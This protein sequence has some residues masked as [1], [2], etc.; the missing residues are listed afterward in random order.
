MESFLTLE[1]A[2]EETM[3]RTAALGTEEVELMD[4]YGRFL[5]KK[6][7]ARLPF[8]AF[9]RS[10]L[11]GYAVRAADLKDAP[12]TLR[13]LEEVGAGQVPTQVVGTGQATRIMTGAPIPVG[14]D[15][16]VRL[17]VTERVDGSHEAQTVPHVRILLTVAAG[18]AI[19]RQ[20]EDTPAGALLL[21]A[22]CQIGGAELA[23]LGANGVDR[24][25]VYRRPRV[26]VIVSGAEVRPAGQ[27]LEAGQVY[28]SNG[29][30]LAGLIREQGGHPILYGQVGDDLEA[31]ARL[32][33]KAAASCDLLLTTGGVSVGDYDL[34]RDAYV[35]AGGE[36]LFWKVSMRP[37]TPV[38]YARVGATP[39]FGL[40]GNPAAA[41]INFVLLV[42]PVLR[43]LA[44][45]AQ[46]EHRPVK[47]MLDSQIDARVIGLDRFLRVNLIMQEAVL[48]AVLPTHSQKAGILTTLPHTDALLR[49]PGGTSVQHGQLVD[50]YPL[51]RGVHT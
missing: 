36:L 47:A 3:S 28:D 11:D 7:T 22:G 31:T 33:K 19:S 35:Q 8:P 20:G 30:M 5:G 29:P 39:V 37:G 9:D 46:P 34:M 4:A 18:E 24:V 44:G 27:S 1:A 26:G 43:K 2:W 14:A 13:V 42:Q 25:T 41:F 32:V 15:A 6:V 10:A 16:I 48:T 17:E 45:H 40:S 38:T 23:V 51:Q 49:I 21:E 12:V 50:V